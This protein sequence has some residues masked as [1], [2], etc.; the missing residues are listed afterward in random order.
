[1]SKA[2]KTVLAVATALVVVGGMLCLVAF[3]AAGF[4]PMGLSTS[5][6]HFEITL[7]D[8]RDYLEDNLDCDPQA[9]DAPAA[10]EAPAAPSASAAPATS[11]TP[12]TPAAS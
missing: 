4:D 3:A 10:P 1:M 7:Y 5:E 11:A 2:R 12:S 8:S 6:D 9:P